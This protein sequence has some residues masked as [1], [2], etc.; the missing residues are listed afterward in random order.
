MMYRRRLL[1]G[2]GLLV[3]AFVTPD[4]ASAQPFE[5]AAAPALSIGQRLPLVSVGYLR[6]HFEVRRP[7][8]PRPEPRID[9]SRE[10]GTGP[11]VDDGQELAPDVQPIDPSQGTDAYPPDIQPDV[12]ELPLLPPDDIAGIYDR[13]PSDFDNFPPPIYDPLPGG[14]L[15]PDITG[16]TVILRLPEA[17]VPC[18]PNNSDC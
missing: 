13:Y 12:Y 9:P 14:P 1:S 10:T 4:I 8:V 16:E 18:D 3:W 5:I 17:I 2:L 11:D 15:G 7:W 6:P